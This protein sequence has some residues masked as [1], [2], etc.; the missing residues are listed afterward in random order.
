MPEDVNS[1]NSDQC[2]VKVFG[3]MASESKFGLTTMDSYGYWNSGLQEFFKRYQLPA[4]IRVT[5]WHRAVRE[6]FT[7]I[8]REDSLI[9]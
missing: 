1:R 8:D 9:H 3:M 4:I 2:Y 6:F 7:P 5:D